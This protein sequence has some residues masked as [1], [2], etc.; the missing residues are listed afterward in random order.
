MHGC[1]QIHERDDSVWAISTWAMHR[2]MTTMMKLE[3]SHDLW[4]IVLPGLLLYSL[5]PPGNKAED[6]HG[7]SQGEHRLQ[8]PPQS[9]LMV[10][11]QDIVSALE[12]LRIVA[13]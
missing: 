10:S 11:S 7:G 2:C 8:V 12:N 6:G 4:D 1:L 13:I 3:D 9:L 5:T